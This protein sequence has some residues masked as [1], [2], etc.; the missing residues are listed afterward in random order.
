M[1]ELR[2]G[3]RVLIAQP[4]AGPEAARRVVEED[5]V[6]RLG[7]GLGDVRSASGWKSIGTI[8][9]AKKA[10]TSSTSGSTPCECP[11]HRTIGALDTNAA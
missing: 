2:G 8:S 10:P 9:R 3:L 6:Q 7:I 1:A 4:A 5:R 11:A